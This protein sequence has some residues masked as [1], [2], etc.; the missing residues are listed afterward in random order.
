M[1]EARFKKFC[2][3]VKYI[4]KEQKNQA[5]NTLELEKQLERAGNI[6]EN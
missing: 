5:A 1:A 4:L 2:N 6:L 3:A